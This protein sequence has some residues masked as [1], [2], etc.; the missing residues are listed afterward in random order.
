M[1]IYYA[2]ACSFVPQSYISYAN[3][4]IQLIFDMR[5]NMF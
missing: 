4:Q 5:H 2:Y 3:S 1:Y